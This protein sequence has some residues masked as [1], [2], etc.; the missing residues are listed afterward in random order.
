MTHAGDGGKMASTGR[1]YWICVLAVAVLCA[2]IYAGVFITEHR[3]ESAV[4]D[5]LFNVA[6]DN[7][8]IMDVKDIRYALWSNRLAVNGLA[9]RN[10][11]QNGFNLSVREVILEGIN[12][13]IALRMFWAEANSLPDGVQ[14]IVSRAVFRNLHI[15]L[16]SYYTLQERSI[17]ELAVDMTQI[18]RLLKTESVHPSEGLTQMI[19][20]S[21][22][23]GK[24]DSKGLRFRY[25]IMPGQEVVLEIDEEVE[26]GVRGGHL[27][28]CLIQG[29]RCLRPD[30]QEALRVEK[31]LLRQL[32]PSQKILEWL[33][34][35]QKS[36]PSFQDVFRELF[37]GE[38]SFLELCEMEGV[39]FVATG[40]EPVTLGLFCWENPRTKPFACA[41]TLKKLRIPLTLEPEFSSLSLLGYSH[42][43]MDVAF[44][45]Q[46]F[47]PVGSSQ[48]SVLRMD[49]TGRDMGTVSFASRCLLDESLTRAELPRILLDEGIRIESLSLC[50]TEEGLIAR[51]AGLGKR[52][53]GVRPES[54]VDTFSESIWKTLPDSEKTPAKQKLLS[55]IQ[56]F[57]NRPGK[58]SVSVVPPVPVTLGSVTSALENYATVDIQEGPRTLQELSQ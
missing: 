54:M 7:G 19:L 1:K 14:P 46:L 50:Y 16:A 31:L 13:N 27:D 43:D 48:S 40:I 49:V 18:R 21:V 53:F 10:E 42:L 35:E 6:Q 4:R 34:E 39:T 8:M 38:R 3:I 22:A 25:E 44:S 32:N 55:R 36:E 26:R 30:G 52:I 9:F 11:E 23:Y 5:V 29:I 37:C 24:A 58:I 41:F 45:G 51:L 20:A 17:E 56:L 12:R 57:L 15:R 28:E 47:Q 2:L 33:C